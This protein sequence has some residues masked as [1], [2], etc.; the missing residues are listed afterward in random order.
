MPVSK[1]DE[2][3]MASW[4]PQEWKFHDWGEKNHENIL[5]TQSRDAEWD[6][7]RKL[8][9]QAWPDPDDRRKYFEW[10]YVWNGRRFA[11]NNYV[12]NTED[13]IE[14]ISQVNFLDMGKVD[15]LYRNI[16]DYPTPFVA[17]GETNFGRVFSGY[18]FTPM[19]DLLEPTYPDSGSDVLGNMILALNI[20]VPHSPPLSPGSSVHSFDTES[21]SNSSASTELSQTFPSP[22]SSQSHSSAWVDNSDITRENS[23]DSAASNAD[24]QTLLGVRLGFSNGPSSVFNAIHRKGGHLMAAI[25]STTERMHANIRATRESGPQDF[26]FAQLGMLWTFTGDWKKAR[27]GNPNDDKRGEWNPNGFAVVVRLSPKGEP[28]KVYALRHP[29]A[30]PQL[31]KIEDDLIEIWKQEGNK[32]STNKRGFMLK[33]YKPGHPHPKSDSSFWIAKIADSIQ[34]LGSYEREFEFKIVPSN[35]PQIVNAKIWIFELDGPTLTPVREPDEID[36]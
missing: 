9:R 1:T 28:G 31:E 22:T 5:N 35:E 2:E 3:I 4:S 13:Y 8:I 16:L 19:N 17:I 26:V 36:I 18:A 23:P 12:M 24:L 33:H 32:K 14:M 30:V 20:H 15:R 25:P 34:E 6:A 7:L 10:V 21:D 11:R 29:N 27:Q